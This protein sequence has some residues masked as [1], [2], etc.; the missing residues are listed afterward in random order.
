MIIY[1]QSFSAKLP[2]FL[3]PPLHVHKKPYAYGY[4]IKPYG[5]EKRHP[6]SLDAF[7]TYFI[8]NS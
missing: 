4:E 2:C 6:Y 1:Y 3:N 5:N 8:H 7:S